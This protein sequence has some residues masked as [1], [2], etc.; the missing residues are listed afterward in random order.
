MTEVWISAAGLCGTTVIGSMLDFITL[1][2]LE[3]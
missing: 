3:Q 2:L 1:V